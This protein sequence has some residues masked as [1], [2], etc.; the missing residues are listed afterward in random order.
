MPQALGIQADISTQIRNAIIETIQEDSYFISILQ[1]SKAIDLISR[2]NSDI[3]VYRCPLDKIILRK[4]PAISVFCGEQ[5]FNA[6]G[7]QSNG[8]FTEYDIYIDCAV[9]SSDINTLQD[10][11]FNLIKSVMITVYSVNLCSTS[12]PT[13]TVA[14]WVWDKIETF[15]D[16]FQEGSFWTQMARL[17]ITAYNIEGVGWFG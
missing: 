8:Q 13:G 17:K 6:Q 10:L 11:L 2:L 4:Y 5:R 16:F 1:D 3:I 9:Q 14:R 15:G 12:Y 7:T